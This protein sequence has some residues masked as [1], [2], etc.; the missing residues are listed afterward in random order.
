MKSELIGTT[1]TK[2][3]IDWSK[4]QLIIIKNEDLKY[5][6]LTTGKHDGYFFTGTVVWSNNINIIT[7]SY[8]DIWDKR[9]YTVLPST[10]AVKLQND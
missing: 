1:E 4:S 7:G 10:T 8:S 6:V 5:I 9:Y 2:K 3:E